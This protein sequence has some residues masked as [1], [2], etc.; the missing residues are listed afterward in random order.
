MSNGLED[1]A[2]QA[3]LAPPESLVSADDSAQSLCRD[4]LGFF[5]HGP[6]DCPTCGSLRL[7]RHDELSA[8]TI[9]HIDCDAFYA[10]VEKRDD[11][12]LRDRPLIVGHAGGRGVV[13]T[14]CYIARQFGPRSAMPMF[15]A[16]QM[17]PDAVVVPPNM[18]KYKA[19]S[20]DIRA[21]FLAA[22]P[23][24]QPVSLD[25]AYMDLSD[26]ARA[27][28][29]NEMS[30]ATS[31]GTSSGAAAL[32]LPAV[33]LAEVA[34][35]IER[36]VGITVSI[37]LSYNKFLAKLASDLEKPRGYSVI[38][39]AEA[40]DFLAPLPVSKINGVGRVTAR[41]MAE[42]GVETIGQLQQM[43]EMELVTRYG[44]FGRSL[45]AYVHGRDNRKVKPSQG[46]KSISA[47]TTF[48]VDT[49]DVA[50][51]NAAV[52]PLCQRVAE[53][54]AVKN[55]AGGTVVLKMKTADFQIL[56]RNRQLANPTQRADVICEHARDLIAGETDG[57]QFRL[58]GIGVSDLCPAE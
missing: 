38:G 30:A 13:T 31:G 49:G 8:L 46:A 3:N 1:S 47:E 19:V 22:T 39:A 34:N 48:R 29:D 57:R 33:A 6:L 7:I 10:S 53:R 52:E 42:Q 37:G 5:D 20:T 27:G 54:L 36:E 44:K 35:R 56:T 32:P 2:G 50:V 18:A 23:M 45:A 21:I 28:M 51:L 24:I 16:M 15:K 9:A 12:S 55:I 14:A 4:C 58:I 41:K 40:R 17:C 25:E 11:P 26:D 43:S